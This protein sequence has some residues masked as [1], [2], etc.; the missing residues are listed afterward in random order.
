MRIC[1]VFQLLL[2]APSN[3]AGRKGWKKS[4]KVQTRRTV[5]DS[6]VKYFLL[7]FL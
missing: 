6:Y 5:I 4:L 1:E 7:L 3:R 2:P